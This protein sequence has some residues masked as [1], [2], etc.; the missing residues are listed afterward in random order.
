MPL[1]VVDHGREERVTAWATTGTATLSTSF[2][3]LASARAQPDARE[4]AECHDDA[5]AERK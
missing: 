5:R 3:A 2:V 1:A 4:R